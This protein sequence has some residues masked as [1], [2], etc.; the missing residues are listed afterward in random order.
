MRALLE[1]GL[2]RHF[3]S[4]ATDPKLHHLL[5]SGLLPRLQF[6][7]EIA[8]CGMYEGLPVE[9]SQLG[10]LARFVAVQRACESL[11]P[12]RESHPSYFGTLMNSGLPR[13]DNTVFTG[14]L[15]L[16]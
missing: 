9:D 11:C 6:I 16:P 12:S 8:S 10:T 5:A 1:G 14:P 15:L 2:E 7:R 3:L 4:R 13:P